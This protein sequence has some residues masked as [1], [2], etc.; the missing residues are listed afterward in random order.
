MAT[1]DGKHSKMAG[2]EN[3]GILSLPSGS[4]FANAAARVAYSVTADDLTLGSVV[5][6]TDSGRDYIAIATGTGATKWRLIPAV[7][8]IAVPGNLTV[9]VS[10]HDGATLLIANSSARAI[11]FPAS[12]HDNFY[13]DFK[14]TG[15]ATVT[16]TRA[17][18]ETVEGAAANF[19]MVQSGG[20]ST[21]PAKASGRWVAYGG[22]WYL[23]P[24]WNGVVVNN[25]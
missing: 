15:T 5:R 21:A 22:A 20:S 13:L 19:S 18:S 9:D 14:C 4:A 24:S 10:L 23:I 12:P 16:W 8:V 6:Q 11:T 2:A 3:H 1:N 25:P 7:V 17:G